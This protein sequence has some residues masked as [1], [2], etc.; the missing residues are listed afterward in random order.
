MQDQTKANSNAA[1]CLFRLYWLF[2]GNALLLFLL[3]FVF[4]N[5]Q[6]PPTLPDAAY[7][8]ILASLLFARYVDIRFLK[9]QTDEGKPATMTHW[10]RY[11]LIMIPVGVGAWLLA[12][13]LSH[14]MK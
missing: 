13:L 3:V 4:E 6:S 7:L 11:L 12:R 14:Y 5:N 9:G 2:I 10:R 8:A 1:G